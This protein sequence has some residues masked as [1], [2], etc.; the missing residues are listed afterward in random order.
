MKSELIIRQYLRDHPDGATTGEIS[1]ELDLAQSLVVTILKC[2]PDTYID[3]WVRQKLVS[4]LITNQFI[5][6]WSIVVPPENC[7]RPPAEE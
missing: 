3:R 5:A 1:R 7:P 6:V 2:M 4:G